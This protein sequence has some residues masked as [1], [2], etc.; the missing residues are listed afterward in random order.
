LIDDAFAE[1]HRRDP[2][3]ERRWVVLVD[4]SRDQITRVKRAAKRVGADI[5]IVLDMGAAP[6][7][8]RPSWHELEVVAARL[9]S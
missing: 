2:E 6:S 7:R 4:G 8:R 9:P 1:A 5:T 3:H